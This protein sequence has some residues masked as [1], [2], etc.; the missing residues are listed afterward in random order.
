MRKPL[1]VL[2]LIITAAAQA[3]TSRVV[4]RPTDGGKTPPP[5]RCCGDKVYDAK[6]K[7]V[8]DVI[9][10]DTYHRVSWA[11]VRYTLA[12]GDT[13]ALLV[14]PWS[15]MSDLMP[16]GSNV[17]FKTANCTGN[18]ALVTYGNYPQLTKRQAV[19][20]DTGIYFQ[21]N[22]TEAWL[23]VS[24][25][26]AMPLASIPPG[27][28]LSQWDSG[29]CSNYPA[30]GYTPSGTIFGAVWVHKVENLLAKYTRPMWTP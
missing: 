7:L 24:D 2:A 23:W 6:G 20:L 25:R 16:G 17:L 29:A 18:D 15:I 9:I 4:P 8:G 10:F 27:P 13:V 22:P 5:F 3:Q 30:P 19:V 1:V 12:D 28:F 26:Y 14:T 11:S 21:Y